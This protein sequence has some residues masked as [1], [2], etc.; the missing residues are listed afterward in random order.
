MSDAPIG[1][2]PVD[3]PSLDQSDIYWD[4]DNEQWVVAGKD[5]AYCHLHS[6]SS[7]K[8]PTTQRLL[9]DA[10]DDITGSGTVEKYDNYDVYKHYLAEFT[11]CLYVLGY[12]KDQFPGLTIDDIIKKVRDVYRYKHGEPSDLASQVYIKRKNIA[13]VR[14][15][16]RSNYGIQVTKDG[17]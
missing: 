5:N 2:D 1:I 3:Y 13:M 9:W 6:P 10:P 16:R 8:Q 12:S 4:K 14:G 7:I 17:R 11:A 15:I